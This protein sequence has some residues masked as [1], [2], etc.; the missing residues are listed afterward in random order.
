MRVEVA[1]KPP[2]VIIEAVTY[3]VQ[4]SSEG[5]VSPHELVITVSDV[6]KG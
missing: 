2:A 3:V 5:I 6:D 1:V 4:G